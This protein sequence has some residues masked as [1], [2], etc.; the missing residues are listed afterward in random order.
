MSSQNPVVVHLIHGVPVQDNNERR[1]RPR[2]AGNVHTSCNDVTFGT[3]LDGDS[4]SLRDGCR[5]GAK[6]PRTVRI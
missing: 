2:C 4:A 1:V 6:L 3:D 5:V